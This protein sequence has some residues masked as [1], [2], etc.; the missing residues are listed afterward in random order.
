M[1]DRSCGSTAGCHTDTDRRTPR[2]GRETPQRQTGC[3]AG[4]GGSPPNARCGHRIKRT[5]VA[6]D[7]GRTH[8]A[9][10]RETISPCEH[11][12]L[13]EKNGYPGRILVDRGEAMLRRKNYT[14]RT[15]TGQTADLPEYLRTMVAYCCEPVARRG[16]LGGRPN[17]SHEHNVRRF[18]KPHL[19]ATER[20]QMNARPWYTFEL[21]VLR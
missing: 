7:G 20:P 18:T 6:I 17:T 3:P 10:C 12:P 4:G 1:K 15:P 2:G 13:L 9:C 8:V 5:R 16:L 19:D 11:S 21:C 14:V